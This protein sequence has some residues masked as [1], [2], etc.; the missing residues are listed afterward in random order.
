MCRADAYTLMAGI[1]DVMDYHNSCSLV[2]G[3]AE[4]AKAVGRSENPGVDAM[5]NTLAEITSL[6]R[7][8]DQLVEDGKPIDLTP[9]L[10]A[11]DKALLEQLEKAEKANADELKKAT[12][13]FATARQAL[14]AET[15]KAGSDAASREPFE[16]K[17][18]EAQANVAKATDALALSQGILQDARVQV[19]VREINLKSA[20]VSA[21]TR[22][23]SQIRHC[24]F[25]PEQPART[26]NPSK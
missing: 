3:L 9:E 12:E 18:A 10:N 21:T 6:R 17:L 19:R 1:E 23:L 13:A 24:P 5:R 16:K 7:Q 26:S 25:T 14:A 20:A 15:A 22:D 11:A 8:A 4:A 2:A